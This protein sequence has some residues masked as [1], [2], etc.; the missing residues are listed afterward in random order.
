[1]GTEFPP[2][3]IWCFSI[4][5]N[6]SSNNIQTRLLLS[7][8]LDLT[9][10]FAVACF[11]CFYLPLCIWLHHFHFLSVLVS[12]S[13][14]HSLPPSSLLSCSLPPAWT[15]W[16]AVSISVFPL[17]SDSAHPV[18]HPVYCHSILLCSRRASRGRPMGLSAWRASNTQSYTQK[19]WQHC[20]K[21]FW[22]NDIAGLK[23]A[24]TQL[25]S[26]IFFMWLD[27]IL[28]ISCVILPQAFCDELAQ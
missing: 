27:W 9:L 6:A 26:I 4:W 7:P 3:T 12:P 24:Y 17:G 20:S 25:M 19:S 14:T 11:D 22:P 15:C 8:Q 13:L 5:V 2:R 16:S 28:F 1:M 18:S 10:C 23:C 21:M